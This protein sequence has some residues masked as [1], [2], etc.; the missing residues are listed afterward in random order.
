MKLKMEKIIFIGIAFTLS[1]NMLFSQESNCFDKSQFGEKEICLPKIDG[2]HQC[3]SIPIIKQLAD[4]TEVQT[5]MVLGYYLNDETYN[6]ID[7]IGLI[8]FDDYFKIYGVKEIQNY[9][10]DIGFL[11][12]MEE[13]L[14][15]SFVKDNWEQISNEIDKL[16]IEAEIGVPQFVEKYNLNKESFSLVML[17]KY[18]IEGTEPYTL[19][20]TINGYLSNERLVWMAY[21]LNYEDSK[22]VEQLKTKSNKILS[23]LIEA[24]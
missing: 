19:V 10:A 24:G 1:F 22:T 21:Y 6:N 13:L 16:E 17:T 18:D 20:M 3:Y 7:S 2:Y 14:T 23:K 15:Q 9:D 12:Q 11:N 4:A 5:N 8:S